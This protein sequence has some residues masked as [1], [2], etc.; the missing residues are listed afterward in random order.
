MAI[1][2][3]AAHSFGAKENGKYCLRSADFTCYSFHALKSITTGG[4]GGAV[5]WNDIY[6]VNNDK[7]ERTFRLLGDHGQTSHDKTC[8]WEYDIA[9]F[10][11]NSIMTNIDAAMGLVQLM[12][13]NGIQDKRENVTA[14]YDTMFDCKSCGVT[15][16][17]EHLG[18]VNKSAMHLY[19]IRLPDHVGGEEG[20]NRIFKT[21]MNVGVPCNVHYK[22]LPMMTAYKNIGFDIKDFPNAY[23]MY[24]NLLTIPYHTSLTVSEQEYVVAKICEAVRYL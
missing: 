2:S 10:G 1:I 3:D 23:D 22:P 13:F 15:P 4:E 9:M 17:I 16:L 18:M 5:A 12:R 8:S 14:I 20:R 19:P 11:Y 6:G 7:L 21:L 24:K